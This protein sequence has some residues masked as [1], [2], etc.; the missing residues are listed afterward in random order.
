M[1][2]FYDL[3]D[4]DLL[5]EVSINGVIQHI[6]LLDILCFLACDQVTVDGIAILPAYSFLAT[7]GCLKIDKPFYQWYHSVSGQGW[8][9]IPQ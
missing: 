3:Q 9:L 1:N 8:L 2:N 6:P 7:D 5:L 4:I